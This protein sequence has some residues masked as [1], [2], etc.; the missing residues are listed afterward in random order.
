MKKTISRLLVL[1]QRAWRIYVRP[2]KES[3]VS[4]DLSGLQVLSERIAQ[5]QT[6]S[7]PKQVAVHPGRQLAFVS[8]MRGHTVQAFDY[9]HNQL[10]L[11]KEWSF[12]EQCVE[13]EVA[14]ELLFV[15]TTNFARGPR[16][17]SHL[18]IVDLGSGEVLPTTA[19]GG[20]WSKVAKM[21][22]NG[23]LAIVSNWHSHDLSVIDVG[24]PRNPQLLQII[25]CG[26][27]PR[28]IVFANKS[29]ALITGFY[30]SRIY[31]LRERN[32]NW[33]VVAESADF[34]PEGYSG[35]M[36]DILVAPDGRHAWVSNL[37]R[38][39]VHR[40][41]IKRGE[42]TKSLSVGR[43]PNSIRFLDESGETLF[44]SCRKDDVVCFV[45]T[46][47]LEVVG[48]SART[49]R[50]PTG[51]AAVEGGFLVTNF[52]DGTLEKH[53]VRYAG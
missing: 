20:E 23:K 28:G 32:G 35:N 9:S 26:E 37:G 15:T 33:E 8:C 11:V 38:N 49:G 39:L 47:K 46:E 5:V 45:D 53:R 2:P 4:L 50:Q 18:A 51:L 29:S 43:H 42:I 40:F 6:A 24:D 31:T 14:G 12:P 16:E 52:A 3:E 19:T 1:A 17:S 44:V 48:K 13:V 25:P 10:K 30:S 27:S 21:H 22:P 36:R 7:E 41:D 34:D